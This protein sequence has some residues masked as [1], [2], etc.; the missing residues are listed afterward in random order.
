MKKILLKSSFIFLLIFTVL[1]IILAIRYF[2][3]ASS[4]YSTDDYDLGNGYG[5]FLLLSSI[6]FLMLTYICFL[7]YKEKKNNNAFRIIFIFG[8]LAFFIFIIYGL[9]KIFG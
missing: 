2:I 4:P 3:I 6:Y 9:I 5:I 1:Y 7:S 8:N